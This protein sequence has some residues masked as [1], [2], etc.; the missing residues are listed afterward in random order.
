MTTPTTAAAANSFPR[1]VALASLAVVLWLFFG[2][3]VPAVQERDDLQVVLADLRSLR[4]QFENAI[5]ERRLGMTNQDTIDLQALLVAIDQ[6][7]LTPAELCATHPL[8]DDGAGAEARK[9]R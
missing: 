1:W 2:Q 4:S 8:A 9:F 5:T 3:T 7:G 6:Q